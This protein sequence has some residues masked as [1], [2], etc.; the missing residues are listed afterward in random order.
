M[1]M[2]NTRLCTLNWFFK[3]CVQETLVGLS[4]KKLVKY[5]L[6]VIS[7][8]VSQ[9]AMAQ[10]KHEIY[11]TAGTGIMSINHNTD[12]THDYFSASNLY[13]KITTQKTSPSLNFGLGYGF[14]FEKNYYL[15]L[16]TIY[17]KVLKN[18]AQGTASDDFFLGGRTYIE[19][20]TTDQLS[21]SALFGRE[22]RNKY[23]TYGKIGYALNFQKGSIAYNVAGRS[24]FDPVLPGYYSQTSTIREGLLL[25]LGLRLPISKLI[26]ITPEYNF[27]DY[28]NAKRDI[29]IQAYPD[30]TVPSS[31]AHRLNDRSF[32]NEFM[33]SINYKLAS[34]PET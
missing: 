16:E 8:A 10:I 31:V 32:A 23:L 30:P 1:M 26:S 19:N 24:P 22:I 6:V 34:A 21:I 20:N 27:I 13:S 9:I 12:D 11:L 4:M 29:N 3:W 14:F 7:C 15:A 5:I 17:S 2:K 33:V 25:G 18:N 28:F